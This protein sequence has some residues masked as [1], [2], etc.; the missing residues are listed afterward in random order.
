[1]FSSEANDKLYADIA[2]PGEK[3]CE[4]CGNDP[5][6]AAIAKRMGLR[7]D[8]GVARI[9][10][11]EGNAREMDGIIKF[12]VTLQETRIRMDARDMDALKR[13]VENAEIRGDWYRQ[14]LKLTN[15][16]RWEH[17]KAMLA[18]NDIADPD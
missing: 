8:I 7:A 14:A 15:P 10:E 9:A 4:V 6:L 16:E 1:M 13:E 2:V 11:L 3:V 17:V 18:A 5:K 12:A